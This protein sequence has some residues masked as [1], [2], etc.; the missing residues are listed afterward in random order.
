MEA[1]MFKITPQNLQVIFNALNELPH[2]VSRPVIDD[3]MIQ[4]QEIEKAA[5]EAPKEPGKPGRKS[6]AD[7]ADKAAAATDAPPGDLK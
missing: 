2:K 5:Q 7:K 3:L 4:A 1:A 6:K